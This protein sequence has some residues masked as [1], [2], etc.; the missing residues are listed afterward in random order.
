MIFVDTWAWLALS[1]KRDP[2]HSSAAQQHR[3]FQQQKARYLTTDYV[4]SELITS[5]FPVV[6]FGKAHR[7]MLNLFQ[8][9]RAGRYQLVHVSPH[10]FER[11]WLVRETYQDKPTM[12]FT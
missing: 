11:A 8:S 7:F 12:S 5:L 10:Q 1:H 4:I 9:V 3:V 6:S 2:Y